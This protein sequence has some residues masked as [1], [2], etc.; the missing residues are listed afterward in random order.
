M[1]RY[2][3]LL[4]LLLSFSLA[5][6]GSVEED[7]QTSSNNEEES[8]ENEI[9]QIFE[10]ALKSGYTGT[11]EEW[12]ESIKGEKGDSIVLQVSNGYIQWKYEESNN[13]INLIS[14]SELAGS[15]GEPGKDGVDGKSTEFRVD[16]NFIQWRYVGEGDNAWKILVSLSTLTGNDGTNGLTPEFRVEEGFIQWKYTT[17][18]SWTNLVSLTTIKGADGED[19]L[20]PEFKVNDTHIRW[21]Y[22]V[23]SDSQ[24]REL[25]SLDSLKGQDGAP[26]QDGQP[27]TD[28]TDGLTPEF[29]VTETHILWKYTNEGEDTWRELVSLDSLKG[30]DGAPGQDGQPGTDGANGLS[31]Y[32]IYIK[33]HPEYNGTEEDWINDLVNGK[34][35]EKE[36]VEVTFDYGTGTVETIECEIGKNITAPETPTREGFVFLGWYYNNEEWKFNLYVV[37]SNITLTA[38]WISVERVDNREAVYTTYEA[39]G[40]YKSSF[41]SLYQAINNCVNYCDTEAYVTKAGSTDKLFI[42]YEYFS[43]GSQDIFWHY[44]GV[45]TLSH[46]SAWKESYWSDL[47]DTDYISVFKNSSTQQLEPYANRYKLVS[48]GSVES[49]NELLVWETCWFLESN[50]TVN[51]EKYNGITKQVYNVDFS[52]AMITPSYKNSDQTNAYIGFITS[53]SYNTS[54]QGIRCDASTGNWYYYCGETST[55]FNDIEMDK[56]NKILTST[57]DDVNKYWKPNQNI[58]LIMELLTLT[59]DSG[60]KTVVHRL[61]INLEDGTTKFFDYESNQLTQCAT[62]QFTCG[63]DIV[64]N[65]S[66]PDY[67]NGGKFE[68]V[69]IT[70]ARGYVYQDIIGTDVYGQ[71]ASLNA[72]E[73]DL[74]NS[75]IASKA[76]RNTLIYTPACVLYDF[77]ITGKDIYSFSYDN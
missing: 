57:W 62:I 16:D 19:G 46:Y 23:E 51:H 5:A 10:L 48:L 17:D 69:I 47:K 32:E 27:G 70:S 21:K 3:L 44:T 65:N 60:D 24:W 13:W 38:K 35:A 4:L 18:S 6:C 71:T 55:D 28:G 43:E 31:A 68:N 15:K 41:A 42:N 77:S 67:M 22:T 39:D 54:H 58:E 53:D 72:G 20:I 45:T 36:L 14:L 12:L 11:Y 64:P 66:F 76:R 61:T 59:D 73:Y 25:V 7:S 40:T 8:N 30:Q 56:S 49:A 63:L 33:Y 2:I 50:A 75:N 52:K 37:N 9:R 1:K 74:L 26:G 34:L 29:K